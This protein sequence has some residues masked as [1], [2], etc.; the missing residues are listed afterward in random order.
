ML[1]A[2]APVQDAV[3]SLRFGHAMTMSPNLLLGHS[4]R[5]CGDEAGRRQRRRGATPQ[6]VLH[7]QQRQP[8][9]LAPH[10]RRHLRCAADGSG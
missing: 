3:Q 8:R 1:P 2:Q 9:V 10:V 5:T 6:R 7:R 4:M